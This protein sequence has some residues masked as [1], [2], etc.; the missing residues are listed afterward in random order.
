MSIHIF[1]PQ[2]TAFSLI[3]L[4]FSQDYSHMQEAGGC[5][6]LYTRVAA[7]TCRHGQKIVEYMN[8]KENSVHTLALVYIYIYIYIYNSLTAIHVHVL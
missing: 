3:F 1:P 4:R 5:F 2:I 8:T 6:I 7:F